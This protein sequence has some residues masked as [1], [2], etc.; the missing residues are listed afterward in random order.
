LL[1]GIG[2]TLSPASRRLAGIGFSYAILRY[3]LL[4]DWLDRWFG[5]FYLAM[6]ITA[7]AGWQAGRGAGIAIPV[8]PVGAD[9]QIN[10]QG[11]VTV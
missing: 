6:G 9:G 2:Y 5:V 7:V 3:V 8:F 4:P 1:G 10:R 11:R